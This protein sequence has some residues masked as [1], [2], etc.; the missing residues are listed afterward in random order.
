M[1]AASPWSRAGAQ[2]AGDCGVV[3]MKFP[4]PE[5]CGQDDGYVAA[6]GARGVSRMRGTAGFNRGQRAWSP[7]FQNVIASIARFGNPEPI[8]ITILIQCKLQSKVGFHGRYSSLP[9]SVGLGQQDPVAPANDRRL[10]G[11]RGAPRSPRARRGAGVRN[12]RRGWWGGS[13]PSGVVPLC[14]RRLFRSAILSWACSAL[15]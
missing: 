13:L 14:G 6:R 11:G 4:G 12:V 5:G 2:G 15:R 3:A 10:I 1:G 8:L 9:P 7:G